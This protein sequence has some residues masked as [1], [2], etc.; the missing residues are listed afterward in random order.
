[1]NDNIILFMS[2]SDLLL[3]LIIIDGIREFLLIF[4]IIKSVRFTCQFP[5]NIISKYQSVCLL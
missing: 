3:N 4:S 5:I 1:M 2:I